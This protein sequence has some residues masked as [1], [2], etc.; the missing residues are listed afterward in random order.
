MKTYAVVN[1][2]N[3]L[4]RR[5][6][7]VGKD[8]RTRLDGKG[9]KPELLGS[10]LKAIATLI[11]GGILLLFTI[12]DAV[13]WWM[14]VFWLVSCLTYDLISGQKDEPGFFGLVAVIYF[15]VIICLGGSIAGLYAGYNNA[16]YFDHFI[17]KSEGFP[18]QNEVPDGMLR[19]TTQELAESIASQHMEEFGSAVTI[20]N[21][22]VVLL[23][24]RLYWLITVAKHEAWGSTYKTAGM[25]AID[26]NDPDKPPKVIKQTFDVA[27]G[28][29]FNPFIGAWGAIVRP[30]LL[31]H[32]HSP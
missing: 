27:E 10:I 19:L 22:H 23:D 7:A 24:G 2:V 11:F 20:V 18:I 5:G 16:I 14:W 4:D 13:M 12:N 1:L 17:T 29:N 3:P 9:K 28:L 32:R 15:V 30:W 25:I 8:N 26:A 21:S 31:Q 6:S